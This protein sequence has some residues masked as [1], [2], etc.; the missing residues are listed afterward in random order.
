MQIA[1]CELQ[2]RQ[3][4]PPVGYSCNG[5]RDRLKVCLISEEYPPETAWGGIGTYTYNLATGLAEQGHE[6]QVIARGW[7]QDSIQE[8]GPLRI[9][10]LFIPEPSWRWGTTR[11]SLKFYETRQILLWNLRV[12]RRVRQILDSD[13]LDVVE[14]PEYHAQGLALA[15]G[16]R[17]VPMVVKLHTPAFLCRNINETSRSLDNRISE[18]L[19]HRLARQAALITSPSRKLAEDVCRRWRLDGRAIRIIPNPIDDELFCP[20]LE[21]KREPASLLFVGRLERRKGVETLIQALPFVRSR[22]LDA[23]LRLVGKDHRSGP[24]GS[25]M[26]EHLRRRL[27]NE[28]VPEEAV[29]YAGAVDRTRLP[30]IYGRA[31]ICVVPSLYEN[32]PYTCLEAMACGCTVIAS[33]VGGIPEIITHGVDGWLVSPES[34]QALADAIDILLSS[35]EL[36]RKLGDQARATI[37]RRFSRQ[38][39]CNQTVEV[40]RSMLEK[41]SAF[42]SRLNM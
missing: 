14:C 26:G 28:R 31:A 40:Y 30:A 23:R 8:N 19:E 4:R 42:A 7:E 25:W 33:A 35:P 38:A 5:K 41:R 11:L 39:V 34:P 13:G 18:Y 15:L 20:P 17:R 22:H 27:R 9:H 2:I 3:P 37:H 32:F 1:N 24:D 16:R 12:R 21:T 10:R 6:V 29:E 36:G